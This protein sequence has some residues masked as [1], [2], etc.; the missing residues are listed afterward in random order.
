MDEKRLLRKNFLYRPPYRWD[1]W[2]ECIDGVQ[3]RTHRVINVN[4]YGGAECPLSPLRRNCIASTL[5]V[6]TTPSNVRLEMQAIMRTVLPNNLVG[7]QLVLDRDYT[8]P[9]CSGA[10][11][12][13]KMLDPVGLADLDQRHC[14]ITHV[15]VPPTPRS[16]LDENINIVNG[17]ATTTSVHERDLQLVLT[18]TTTPPPLG[19]QITKDLTVVYSFDSGGADSTT[20]GYVADLVK[21]TN[22]MRTAM[23]TAI[24]DPL[25]KTRLTSKSNEY[26]STAGVSIFGIQAVTNLAKKTPWYDHHKA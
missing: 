9:L 15:D 17:P 18:T 19:S 1:P 23:Y 20:N 8:D 7:Q 21:I 4:A 25:F 12:A 22:A 10:V 16:L 11:I 6:S 14:R 13:L 3:A 24:A 5:T 2:G 26:L